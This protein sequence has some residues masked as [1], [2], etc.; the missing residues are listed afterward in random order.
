M[1]SV[2]A[3]II[4][5]EPNALRLMEDMLCRLEGVLVCGNARSLEE[6]LN[7]VLKQRP[8]IVFLDIR[9]HE[10]NGFELIRKLKE[11]DIDP[12]FV[13]VTGFDQYGMEAL[14]AGAFDY[15]LKPV[16]PE[17]LLKVIARYRQKKASLKGSSVPDKLKFNI[18]GGFILINPE[19]IL[20]CQAEANYT[21]VFLITENKHTISQN[22]GT[23]ENSLNAKMFFR[24]S[25]SIIINM[26]YLTGINRSKKNCLLTFGNKNYLISMAENR[27]SELEKALLH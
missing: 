15:L 5:D 16:D 10:E 23:I 22:L 19:E 21:D 9:L 11:Y 2:K 26:K 1:F 3:V 6:G 8:D 17:E 25:R 14:K 20:Y 24:V 13:M 27:I 7:L 4:D 18:K 12:Y